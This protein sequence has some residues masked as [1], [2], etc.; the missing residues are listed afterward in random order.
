MSLQVIFSSPLHK[1]PK[2]D[3]DW[4]PCGDYRVLNKIT[5]PDRYPIPHTQ[6][7]TT[8]LHGSNIFSKLDLVK[9]FHHVPVEPADV[10]KTAVTT[11]FGLFEFVRM[12]FGLRNAAQ[13]FQRF[14][15]QVFRGLYFC[16]V[17]IDDLLVASKSPKEHL[18][19]LR[20]V[21]ERLRQYSLTI[22]V[23]KSSFGQIEL[24][25]LGHKVTGKS[26]L[27]LPE[28][29]SAIKQFPK[30]SS[31]T[32]LR[33]F[34]GLINFYHR[35]IH[36]CAHLLHPLHLF[37]NNLPK[38]RS[39][40]TLHWTEETS[41]AFQDVK[42]ARA[43]A[44]F[45]SY[46]HPNAPINLMVDASN[47]AVGAILQQQVNDDWQ[48][49]SF[50]SRSLSPRE[51]KYST[52]DRELLATF[53]TVKHFQHHLHNPNFHILTVH[54]PLIYAINS[55]NT[56][57]SP[58]QAR[59]LDYISQF[60]TDLRRVHR[61]QNPVADALSR[62][63]ADV[64]MPSPTVPISEL[65]Q[66]QHTDVELQS[67]LKSPN[68]LNL[69]TETFN[70]VSLICDISTGNPRPFVPSSLRRKLFA[71]FH[72]LSHP[73]VRATQKLIKE[74]FVWPRISADIRDWTK[75][76]TSCQR[77]K[78]QRHTRTPLHS[79]P[80]TKFRFA[81]VHLSI[82]GPLPPSRGYSYLFTMVDRFSRWPEVNP[83]M[84]IQAQTIV[85]A[86]LSGWVSRFGI[87]STVTT[88]RRAQ[89]ESSLFQSLF[90]QLGITRIRTTSYHPSSNGMVERLHRTLK[91]SL[92]CHNSADWMGVLPLVLL[93]IRSSFKRDLGCCS[94][95][96]LYGTPLHLP[97]KFFNSPHS[98]ST[99]HSFLQT[100]SDH[101]SKLKPCPP[102]AA[103][104]QKPFVHPD[105]NSSSHVF[106]RNDAVQQPLQQPYSGPY[107]VLKRFSK[108]FVID[109]RGKRQCVS[110][111]RLKPAY[112]ANNEQDENM[113][114]DFPKFPP[115]SSSPMPR[116]SGRKVHFPGYLK[117]FV[118]E[119]RE[120]L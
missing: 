97:G 115:L 84:E 66:Q 18:L 12:P 88:D 98:S 56:Q 110:K 74:R 71:S 30:P 105:L 80:S 95:L 109:Y 9:A 14:M 49:I 21:F 75:T 44:T 65:A 25:F 55:L 61:V 40:Q 58:R 26:V 108:T 76:C 42:D 85:K 50:F 43:S 6:D 94:V 93:G 52:F 83:L 101:I 70:H 1:V 17:Y 119:G 4:R 100:L 107:K 19:H 27:P 16:Y 120:A 34:L 67:Y 47:T 20:Q 63:Q 111:D 68:S 87:C 116:H 37:L 73:G 15:D 92:K 2:A 31:V 7:F 91:T 99:A 51:R 48:P 113:N 69:I 72:N 79:F 8:S 118:V 64:S 89:F 106:L 36:N 45:L 59:Q 102:R 29:V 23:A 5:V 86:F 13:T 117:D 35:F 41:T 53:L 46:P 112:L 22:S 104:I 57:H 60:T 90:S 54:K 38:S 10:H 24:T 82:V 11:P 3:G 28:K 62:M 81:H 39:K 78:I 96:M 32:Q 103:I 114:D 33:R 77:S